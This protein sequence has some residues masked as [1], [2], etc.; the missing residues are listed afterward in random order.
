MID[1]FFPI[2]VI[3]GKDKNSNE[4]LFY[5]Q[6]VSRVVNRSAIWSEQGESRARLMDAVWLRSGIGIP[7]CVQKKFLK[8]F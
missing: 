1:V 5:I 2:I 7:R 8:K 4:M 6:I 3:I